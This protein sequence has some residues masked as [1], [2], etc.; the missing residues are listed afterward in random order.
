MSVSRCIR[1]T[2]GPTCCNSG[3][4]S[5]SFAA[6]VSGTHRCRWHRCLWRGS[7]A[8]PM[9]GT[10]S[11]IW[12]GAVSA[13]RRASPG[14]TEK[15][16][17]L[18]ISHAIIVCTILAQRLELEDEALLLRTTTSQ[19]R[20]RSGLFF[21]P[22]RFVYHSTLGSRVTTTKKK[23]GGFLDNMPFSWFLDHMPQE[24]LDHMSLYRAILS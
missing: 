24:F 1:R 18:C 3:A 23:D 7:Y 13:P 14:R 9:A 16:L 19:K 5:S 2:S 4:S 15:L 8:D 10:G 12:W 17:Q 22:H 11:G 20:F 6:R 21:D